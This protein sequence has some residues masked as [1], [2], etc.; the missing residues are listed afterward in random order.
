MMCDVDRW[1]KGNLPNIQP[2]PQSLTNGSPEAM[3][4]S[5]SKKVCF[6]FQR[7]MTSGEPAVTSFRSVI[8]QR[9]NGSSVET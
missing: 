5:K 7:L 3:M 2:L 8:L 4:V 9:D 6:F 1:W